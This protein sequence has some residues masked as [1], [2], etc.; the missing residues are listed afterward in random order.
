MSGYRLFGQKPHLPKKS[1]HGAG[2]WAKPVQGFLQGLQDLG[3]T[4]GQNIAI[5]YR[6]AEGHEERLP[7]LAAELVQLNVD[8]ILAGGSPAVR[9]A[10]D[11]T[12]T[13]PIV[14]GASN[15]PVEAGFV[16]SLARPGGNVTGLSLMAPGLAG[17]RLDLLREAVPGITRVAVLAHPR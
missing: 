14:I 1:C 6:W 3:Y 10:K 4:D 7:A 15:D 12:S 17:K 11:A 13:I 9:A 2:F 5:E 8:I 16:T